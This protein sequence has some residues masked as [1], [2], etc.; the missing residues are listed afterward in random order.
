M[1]LN[2]L[3]RLMFAINITFRVR[4]RFVMIAI[5]RFQ[6]AAATGQDKIQFSQTNFPI[7]QQNFRGRVNLTK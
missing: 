3:N 5:S 2:D 4:K 6:A 1:S 7:L